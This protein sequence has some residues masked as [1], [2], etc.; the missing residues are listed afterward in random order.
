MILPPKNIK[1]DYLAYALS[2]CFGWGLIVT[3]IKKYMHWCSSL[4]KMIF[5]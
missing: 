1:L 4:A 5:G 3:T 2:Q